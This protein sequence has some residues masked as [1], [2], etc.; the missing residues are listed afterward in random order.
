MKNLITFAV[1]GMISTSVTFASGFK[2]EA[3]NDSGFNAKLFNKTLGAT[4]TPAVLVVSNEEA[5]PATLLKRTNTE[6]RKYNTAHKV[7]YVVDGNAAIGA[8][9]VTLQINFKE[10]QE[11]IDEGDVVEG[12]LILASRGRRAAIPM[13]CVRYLKAN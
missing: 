6:I 13:D 8:D 2:C 9:T 5:I 12:Q 1:I 11:T 7:Q 3:T 4:R 10:G